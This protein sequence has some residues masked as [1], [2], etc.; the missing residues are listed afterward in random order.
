M[1][2]TMQ[3]RM[4]WAL[5]QKQHGVITRQQLLRL[6]FTP[7]AIRHRIEEGRLHPIYPGVYA[8]GRRELSD[9][10]PLPPQF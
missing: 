6:G 4:A 9:T 10:A 5:V 8:V 2:P 1:T 7:D 3:Q